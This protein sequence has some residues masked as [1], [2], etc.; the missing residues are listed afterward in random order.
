[1]H[2]KR[3]KAIESMKVQFSQKVSG[4]RKRLLAPIAERAQEEVRYAG[5]PTFAYKAA[6]WSVDK[7]NVLISPVFEINEI[8][9]Y[10]C[11]PE[12]LRDLETEP[13]GRLT[14]MIFP[15]QTEEEKAAIMQALLESK[16]TLIRSALGIDQALT[17][18]TTKTGYMLSFFNATLDRA[19]ITVAAQLSCCI[20]EQAIRQKRVT[21]KDKA[22]EN[23]KYAFRCF[24]LHI[25]M[26]G[27]TYSLARKTL[28]ASLAGNGSFKSGNSK[29]SDEEAFV[30]ADVALSGAIDNEVSPVIVQSLTGA[31]TAASAAKEG[32]A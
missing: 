19:Y 4:G 11:I 28:L 23:E 30:S 21:A 26:I 9:S 1:M 17:V 5:A 25:G 22:V 8:D 3:R 31:D 24:L 29:R 16:E 7:N 15:D 10:A 18:A 20:Y 6:G 14:L 2:T 12:L 32:I 13:E 27:K